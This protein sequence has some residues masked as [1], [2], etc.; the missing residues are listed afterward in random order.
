M[1]KLNVLIID[2]ITKRNEKAL[3]A[4]IMNANFSSI[5]PQVIATWC[6][7]EGH[8]VTLSVYTGFEDLEKLT[9][10]KA[11][12]V[13]ISSFTQAALKAYAFSHRFRAKGAVTV[14]GGPHARCYP[15]DSQKHFDYVFGFTNK[16]LILEVLQDC[17]QHRPMGMLLSADRQPVH[18]PGVKE[19]WKFVEQTLKKAPTIKVVPMIASMGCPYTCSFCIDAAVPYSPMDYEVIKEDLRFLLTKYKR[20]VVAWHDPNF[21]IRFKEC[22]NAIEEAVPQGSI[23]FIAESSLS[24]LSEGHLKRLQKNGFGAILPG[25]ES[26]YD[27]G[28]KS[29]TGRRQGEEKVKLVSEHINMI[30]HYIPYVQANF[31]LGLDHE[32]GRESYELTKLFVDKSPGA[33]PSYS[34]LNSFGKS[35]LLNLN[36]QRSNRVLPV[37]VHF[38]NCNEAMNVIPL[39]YSWTEFYDHVIDLVG[40]S[41][42]KRANYRRFRANR[43]FTTKWMNL[44]RAVSSVGHGRWK[45]HRL[46]R[47]HLAE[48]RQF[49]SFMD[50]KSETIP[51]FFVERI[52]KDLGSDWDWLPEGAIYHDPNAYLKSQPEQ[53]IGEMG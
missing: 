43:T 12:I 41:F 7:Q 34:L 42:S 23:D 51:A 18:L 53:P 40:Y 15:E 11:D 37:P 29:K 52:K 47:R 14:L 19:R 28:N 22:M 3:Y 30:Q 38:L 39:N 16:E 33:F 48:D 27:M 24:L 46:F 26:W 35:A 5:M 17:S 45:Y 36:Y 32:D 1:R 50:G 6:E 31:V 21:G 20:P 10:D 49:R 44:V 4:R 9:P 25:I 13:F 2:L 8:N